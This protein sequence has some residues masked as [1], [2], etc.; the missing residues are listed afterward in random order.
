MSDCKETF[1]VWLTLSFADLH[2]PE[3]HRL[4][5]GSSAYLDKIVVSSLNCLPEDANPEFYI[6]AA[7][8]NRLRAEAVAK[9]G[10]IASLYLNK[11]FW[12]FYEHILVPMGVIDYILRVE[13]QWR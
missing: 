3:L 13:F 11:K 7:T 1:N 5:P 10:D 12:L 4:L 8:D 2:D 6:D 9:N